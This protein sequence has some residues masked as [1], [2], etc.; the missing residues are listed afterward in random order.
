MGYTVRVD[1]YRYTEWVG[2]NKV[3]SIECLPMHTCA[4]TKLMELLTGFSVK[5][6]HVLRLWLTGYAHQQMNLRLSSSLF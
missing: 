2:F 6:R 4:A 3:E 1:Q 5:I